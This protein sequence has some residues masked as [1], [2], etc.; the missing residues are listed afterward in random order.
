LYGLPLENCFS[1]FQKLVCSSA[2]KQQLV[3][4]SLS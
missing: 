2:T 1:V 3:Y 4:N